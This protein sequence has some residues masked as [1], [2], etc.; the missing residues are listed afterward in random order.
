[1]STVFFDYF[2]NAQLAAHDYEAIPLTL[3]NFNTLF[4]VLR[5]CAREKRGGFRNLLVEYDAEGYFLDG[6]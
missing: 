6:V 5:H 4:V 2:L 3:E 1:L